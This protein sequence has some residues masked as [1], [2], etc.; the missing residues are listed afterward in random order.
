MSSL[1]KESRHGIEYWRGDPSCQAAHD[2]FLGWITTELTPTFRVSGPSDDYARNILMGNLGECLTFFVAY[3]NGFDSYHAFPANALTPLAS[4]SKTSI[5]LLWLH[6]GASSKED[7]AILQEVKATGGHS[8]A[9]ADK[10][11]DDYAKLFGTNYQLT[12]KTRLDDVKAQLRFR[13]KLPAEVCARVSE[14]GGQSPATSPR[15]E[16]LPTLVH[17]RSSSQPAPKMI[18]IRTSLLADG[19]DANSV[20]LWTISLSEL[21]PRLI[22]LSKGQR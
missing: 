11:L 6:L 18:A 16:L 17:D 14:L 22:R 5:D 9:Y 1:V 3:Q 13:H 2:S 21:V 19:W 8:L 20:R 4:N 10:L 12:L 7:L 15:I